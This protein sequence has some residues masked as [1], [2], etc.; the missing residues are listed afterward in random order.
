MRSYDRPKSQ[1]RQRLSPSP[2]EGFE[3]VGDIL[4]RAWPEIIAG[5]DFPPDGPFLL[6]SPACPTK[7]TVKGKTWTGPRR[8]PWRQRPQPA[9]SH[10]PYTP[11]DSE[12]A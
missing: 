5:L 3:H 9:S 10:P 11:P 6:C 7:P 12:Q 2:R 4:A 8:L 1:G